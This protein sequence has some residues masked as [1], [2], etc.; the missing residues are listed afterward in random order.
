MKKVWY[1]YRIRGRNQK[2]HTLLL[3]SMQNEYS[4]VENLVSPQLNTELSEYILPPSIFLQKTKSHFLFLQ[5]NRILLLKITFL[6]SHLQ[7]HFSCFHI[8]TVIN[9]TATNIGDGYNFLVAVFI[10]L[11]FRRKHNNIFKSSCHNLYSYQQC[12]KAS[13]S[14]RSTTF[15][16]ITFTLFFGGEGAHLHRAQS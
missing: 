10:L 7:R 16:L 3:L 4:S 11:S 6:F 14:A 2:S 5:L 1:T 12:L 13:L 15:V 8:L 9:N